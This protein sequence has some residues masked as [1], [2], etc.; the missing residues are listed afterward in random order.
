MYMYG[1]LVT[2]SVH[3]SISF[4]IGP[5][6]TKLENVG[7][8]LFLTIQVSCCLAH[9][10]PTHIQHLSIWN[11]VMVHQ[12]NWWILSQGWFIESFDV[13]HSEWSQVTD[14]YLDHSN[15]T[16][17]EGLDNVWEGAGTQAI[18]GRLFNTNQQFMMQKILSWHQC[19]LKKSYWLAIRD[20]FPL[21]LIFWSFYIIMFAS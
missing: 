2:S 3:L 5:I 18:K 16:H 17:S 11:H 13:L 4:N 6:N 12:V 21:T 9:D 10:K 8:L 19:I 20:F 7:I 1:L 15:G 14:P